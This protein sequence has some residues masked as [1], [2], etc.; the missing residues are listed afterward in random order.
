VGGR[1]VFG[2]VM[3]SLEVRVHLWRLKFSDRE[4]EPRTWKL[5]AQKGEE[6]L[7][8]RIDQLQEQMMMRNKLDTDEPLSPDTFIYQ[9][10]P[11]GD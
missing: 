5:R 10:I 4:H 7:K 11:D 6:D 1:G 2:V 8:A 3:D 9:T